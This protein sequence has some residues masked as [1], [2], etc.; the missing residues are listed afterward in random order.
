MG[1]GGV[2][3]LIVNILEV[4]LIVGS[5]YY[6][7]H[8]WKTRPKIPTEKAQD[9]NN[10]ITRTNE[11]RVRLQALAALWGVTASLEVTGLMIPATSA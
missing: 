1:N 4:A 2:T 3:R 9:Y 6:I 8:I 7:G 5:V 10:A 11:M